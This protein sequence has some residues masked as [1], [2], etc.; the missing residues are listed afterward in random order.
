[1]ALHASLVDGAAAPCPG[2]LAKL[3]D[4]TLSPRPVEG[5]LTVEARLVA[6]SDDAGLYAFAVKDALGACC[7]GRLMIAFTA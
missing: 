6:R 2:V 3:G 4:V 1:V 5:A 7:S